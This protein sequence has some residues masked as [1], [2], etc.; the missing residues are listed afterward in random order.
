MEKAENPAALSLKSL[1][2]E[3][4]KNIHLIGLNSN[5]DDEG[6]EQVCDE[7]KQSLKINN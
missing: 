3:E 1:I 2:N 5:S 6:L 7:N 4:A